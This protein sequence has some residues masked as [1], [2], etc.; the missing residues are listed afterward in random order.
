DRRQH[1]RILQPDQRCDGDAQ[2]LGC[3]SPIVEQG[4]WFDP[5]RGRSGGNRGGCGSGTSAGHLVLRSVCAGGVTKRQRAAPSAVALQSDAP[6]SQL[7]GV[8][9]PAR[10]D[11]IDCLPAAWAFS[12]SLRV[13]ASPRSRIW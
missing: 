6:R 5:L 8:I 12:P 10:T 2:Q 13:L 4:S 11:T 7:L 3:L 1:A 9:A